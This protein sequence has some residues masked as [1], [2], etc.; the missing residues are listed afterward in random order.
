M[1]MDA[2]FSPCR[3]WRYSLTRDVGLPDG[4]GV[5]TFIGLNPSTADETNNDPTTRRC[6]AFARSWGFARMH[7]I[8]VY[9]FRATNPSI[10]LNS[11]RSC[12]PRE[13][14]GG[15]ILGVSDL[16][17]CAWGAHGIGPSADRLLELVRV[18]LLPWTHQA[19]RPSAS[20]YVKASTT[21]TPFQMTQSRPR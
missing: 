12:R 21:P 9:A 14:D 16:V 13:P 18:P 1:D 3:T 10:T 6:V 17:I 19:R 11:R 8:N 2:R 7:L 15:E 20:S 4:N 5:V